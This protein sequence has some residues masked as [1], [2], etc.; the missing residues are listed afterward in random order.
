MTEQAV[1]QVLAAHSPEVRELAMKT[2]ALVREVIPRAVEE[3]DTRAGLVGFTFVPGT[4]RGLVVAVFPQRTYVNLMF[5][6]GVELLALDAGG[7]LEGTGKQA[8][9]VKVRS[10]DRLADPALRAL[11]EAAAARTAG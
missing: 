5:A 4:Y 3:V 9:H 8:R 11:I 2:R 7:L 6:K 1:V 10:A